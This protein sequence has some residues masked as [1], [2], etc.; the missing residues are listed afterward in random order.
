MKPLLAIALWS[1]AYAQ[2]VPPT[3]PTGNAF[4]VA[5]GYESPFAIGS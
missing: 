2:N 4:P 3:P 5:P 1:V